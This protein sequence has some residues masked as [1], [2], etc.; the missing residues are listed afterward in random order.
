M[1]LENFDLIKK[2]LKPINART[3]KKIKAKNKRWALIKNLHSLLV[4]QK[5]ILEESNK[6]NSGSYR[7][8]WNKILTLFWEE[9]QIVNPEY[10][11]KSENELIS[12]WKKRLKESL[13]QEE[14]ELLD[15]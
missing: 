6:L 5:Q 10:W 4:H 2:N 9:V 8:I 13:T 7:I 11:D 12:N 3:I 15:I 1:E 14:L